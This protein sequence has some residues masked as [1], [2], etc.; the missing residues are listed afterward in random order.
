MLNQS[1]YITRYT[2][3]NQALNLSVGVSTPFGSR[4]RKKELGSLKVNASQL[5]QSVSKTWRS[6]IRLKKF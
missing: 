2:I 3:L 6:W 5:R 1:L 4:C